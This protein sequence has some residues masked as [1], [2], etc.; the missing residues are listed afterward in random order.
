MEGKGMYVACREF[1]NYLC[2]M[3]RLFQSTGP[4]QFVL[5]LMYSALVHMHGLLYPPTW[6][7]Q[8][9]TF[10][11]HW[12][13]DEHNDL[14][15]IPVFYV[16][17]VQLILITATGLALSTLM[18][19]FKLVNKPTLL[20]AMTF[21][22]LCSFF[23]GHLLALPEV[24]SGLLILAILFKVFS[25]Y[26]KQRCDMT[27]FDAGALS[28]LA[29]LIYWP[30]AILLVFSMLAMLRMRS[31]TF[32]EFVIYLTGVITPVFLLG[33]LV[34][35]FGGPEALRDLQMPALSFFRGQAE[36]FSTT[37]IVKV[38]LIGAVLI[39]ALL[40]FAEKI[41]SNLIQ[42]R[43]Y[44]SVT[45]WLLLAGI[46]ALGTAFPAAESAFYPLLL[47]AAMVISY[48]FFHSRQL[49]YTEGAHAGLL[50]ATIILQYITFL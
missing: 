33:T 39:L 46:A 2:R 20:P 9:H 49:L 45:I 10:L 38:S 18:Q 26:N 8:M 19:R 50:I 22:L 42:I 47:P 30:S 24:W 3:L 1:K 7:E 43:R 14:Q 6:P 27:Y 28:V 35:W 15:Q 34:F 4:L 32:R 13:L 21:V 41:S 40:L 37:V 36:L 48:Y 29:T 5:L 12:L 44:M 25:A 16:A 11:S 17:L 31:T 23:P